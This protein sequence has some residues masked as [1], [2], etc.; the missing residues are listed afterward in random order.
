MAGLTDTLTEEIKISLL[1]K[2]MTITTLAN[3]M[4]FSRV[5]ISDIVNGNRRSEK[6]NEHLKE[7]KKIL[8]IKD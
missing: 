8:E 7:I 1:K 6:S 2:K 3:Q 4:G 5:Y